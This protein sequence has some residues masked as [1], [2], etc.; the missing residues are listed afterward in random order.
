M[1]CTWKGC[2]KEASIP[3]KDRNGSIWANLC[4]DHDRE[5]NTALETLQPK[6]IMRAWIL[7]SGGAQKMTQNR[8]DMIAS[9]A[10]PKTAGIARRVE[11][12]PTVV[13]KLALI[14]AVAAGKVP[15]NVLDENPQVIK[16]LVN[17][18]MEIPGVTFEER[19]SISVR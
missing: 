13:N 16:K 5:I 17:A 1:I 11:K 12:I 10:A 7:A 9:L 14:K 6:S 8:R 15:P 3:Q 19:T 18:G 4:T 2:N